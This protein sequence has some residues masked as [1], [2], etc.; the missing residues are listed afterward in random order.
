VASAPIFDFDD[1]DDLAE[2]VLQSL[3]DNDEEIEK[4][5]PAERRELIQL[6]A[7]DER[8]SV[9]AAL[10][11]Y[12]ARCPLPLSDADESWFRTLANDEASDVR[13]AFASGFTRLLAR[14][15]PL[16]RTDLISSWT[17]SRHEHERLAI[18]RAL[19]SFVPAVG[20]RWATRQLL[21][22]PSAE[23]RAAALAAA[24]HRLASS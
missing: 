14:A 23:V 2:T 5:Q 3:D 4:W 17:V 18:A 10:V 9:R 7:R 16:D 19:N 1:S 24:P 12:V 15:S 21:E 11:K 13:S 22:D 8:V 20:A 6:L